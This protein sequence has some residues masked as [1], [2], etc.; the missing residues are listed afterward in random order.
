[1]SEKNI[2]T[3]NIKKVSEKYNEL[4][5]KKSGKC[6]K[7]L[8][9]ISNGKL[10]EKIKNTIN[11]NIYL[12]EPQILTYISF[13]RKELEKYWPLISEEIHSKENMPINI[14]YSIPEY[15]ISN[16]VE[17]LRYKKGYF[18]DITGTSENISKSIYSNLKTAAYMDTDILSTGEK[19]YYTK[20]NKDNLERRSYSQNDE[21]IEEYTNSLIKNSVIDLPI[22][23]YLYTEKLLKNEIYQKNLA[24]RYDCIIVDSI[25]KVSNSEL[26][27]IEVFEKID[28]E[29]YLYG[30]INNDFSILSNFDLNNIKKYIL[31]NKNNPKEKLFINLEKDDFKS[32]NKS[33]IRFSD[34]IKECYQVQ[35]YT[36]MIKEVLDKVEEIS[37][38]GKNIGN[39]A[40]IIPS[41]SGI[42]SYRISEGLKKLGI[43]YFNTGTDYKI[44]EYSYAKVLIMISAMYSMNNDIKFSKEEYIEFLSIVL[45]INRI[46]ANKIYE[47][48][49][50]I[51]TKEIFKENYIKM[52]N[53]YDIDYTFEEFINR[54]DDSF[55]ENSYKDIEFILNKINISR[56]KKLKR[57]DF[58]R[59]FYIEVLLPIK[60]GVDNINICKKV[61]EECEKL[62]EVKENGMIKDY[63]I[64]I[65]L[66]NSTKDYLGYRE[67]KNNNKEDSIMITSPYYYI[68]SLSDRR[69]QLWVDCGN[70]MWNPKISKEISN[71][72]VLRKSYREREIFT[73]ID[74]ENLKKY[75][76][77][78]QMYMLL[79]LAEEVY[80]FKS[81]YSINGYL[82]E[83]MMYTKVINL[84]DK[85]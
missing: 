45:E 74:E 31:D 24:K 36:E 81:D 48:N 71:P 58:M 76:L 23:I 75:Y 65:I 7:I 21:I 29:I 14:P 30:N 39:S 62:E 50:D 77:N 33:L 32:E 84:M 57:S 54:E 18:E 68:N 17:N 16:K 78:N 9:L 13:I 61:I 6:S 67:L 55:T 20:K 42:L 52:E 82:Q 70:S 2:I 64:E 79:S 46:K 27:L 38:D 69:I 63:E 25:E 43:K 4:I 72:A 73:D 8:F 44:S 22:S 15:I 3:N 19:I 49:K 26:N 35:L 85:E 53:N 51:L 11:K 83:N 40:I 37:K 34:K 59:R 12:E 47:E 1:M 5:T 80:A 56:E 60:D 28:K 41:G 66:N 10:I